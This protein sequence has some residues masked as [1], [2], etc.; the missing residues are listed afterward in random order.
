MTIERSFT[1]HRVAKYNQL[2]KRH[3]SPV[4]KA[5][6]HPYLAPRQKSP[7]TVAK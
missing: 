3:F 2:N 6:P 4:D 7:K 5:C 1:I